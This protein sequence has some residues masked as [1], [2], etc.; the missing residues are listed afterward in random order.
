MFRKIISFGLII[1]ALIFGALIIFDKKMVVV[2][3]N[4]EQI[5]KSESANFLNKEVN[6]PANSNS[7]ETISKNIAQQLAALK[8]QTKIKAEKPEELANKIF[9]EQVTHFEFPD[10]NP[11]IKINDLKIV[12]SSDKKLAENYFKNRQAI[13]KNNLSILDLLLSNPSTE[14]FAKIS[15][16]YE[17][18]VSQFYNLI[19]PESLSANHREEIRL[20]TIQKNIF[21]NLSNY[22][23][24]PLKA[25]VSAK[26]LPEVDHNLQNLA[27]LHSDFVKKNNLNI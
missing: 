25:L 18:T 13:I 12:K 8:N 26:L 15:K 5:P 11:E 3:K 6:K 23:A 7:T 16:A 22:G 14:D 2:S 10:L 27:K 17:R 21:A 4:E 20:L 9:S 19:V 24:D 1:G